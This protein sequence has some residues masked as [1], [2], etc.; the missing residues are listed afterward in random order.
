[1][2]DRISLIVSSRAS[3]ALLTRRPFS[4]S[5]IRDGDALQ[6]HAGGVEPLDDQVVQIPGDPVPVLEDRQTFRIP[7]M[8]GELQADASLAGEDDQHLDGLRGQR[9]RARTAAAVGYP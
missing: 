6:R 5:P 7:A 4:D 8:L 2:A 1:M 9:Q 3:T